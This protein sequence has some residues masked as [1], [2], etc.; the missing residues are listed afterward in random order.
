MICVG[1]S[2]KENRIYAALQSRKF[3]QVTFEDLDFV[4]LITA[5]NFLSGEISDKYDIALLSKL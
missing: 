1:N 3:K 2:R 5:Y 4:F